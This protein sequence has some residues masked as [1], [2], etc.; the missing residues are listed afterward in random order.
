MIRSSGRRRLGRSSIEEVPDMLA[1]FLPSRRAGLAA[2]LAGLVL[3]AAGLVRAGDDDFKFFMRKDLK[4]TIKQ[5]SLQPVR[6]VDKL[7]KIWDYQKE[8]EPIRFDTELFRCAIPAADTEG[9]AYLRELMSKNG[10]G[11]KENEAKA[12]D[13]TPP[14]ICI[15]G[16]VEPNTLWGAGKENKDAAG[17]AEDELIIMV[18]KVEK[19]RK[20]FF[21]EGY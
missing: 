3:A 14:L 21:D 15:Q 12:G 6:T 8:G 19:P 18:S 4:A 20:R 2:L 16:R 17:Q 1:R 7:V 11:E 13:P 10:G 5:Q 9:I